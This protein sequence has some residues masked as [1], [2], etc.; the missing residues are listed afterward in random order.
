MKKFL[1]I[2]LCKA[3][4]FAG[5]LVGKGSSMPGKLAL[6]ICPDILSRLTLPDKIIAVTGSNGKTSTVE[7]VVRCLETAGMS[8]VWNRE[9]SN[10]IEGIATMLL[11]ASTVGGR[12]RCEA[13]MMES[14]EQNAR[15]KF[16]YPGRA[17]LRAEPS[18][19][20]QLTRNGHPSMC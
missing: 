2:L 8:V 6:R 10:Q 5:R 11:R 15:H 3:A 14:E 18:C 20:D 17:F 12:V 9:G 7:M 1:A 13:V 16:G 4:A 19:R